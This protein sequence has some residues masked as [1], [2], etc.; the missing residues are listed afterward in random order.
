[1]VSIK[2][3]DLLP[4]TYCLGFGIFE[5]SLSREKDPAE[6]PFFLSAYIVGYCSKINTFPIWAFFFMFLN[7]SACSSKS[8]LPF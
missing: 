8:I 5:G 6:V 3:E 7:E 1:M 2:H 4:A